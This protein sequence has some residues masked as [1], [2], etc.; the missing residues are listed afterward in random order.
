[1]SNGVNTDRDSVSVA[2]AYVPDDLKTFLT[3]LLNGKK[4][5]GDISDKFTRAAE[6]IGHDIVYSVT[7]GIRK[8]PK[9]ILLPFAVKSL[10]G[11][12]ELEEIDAILCLNK[13]SR[14]EETV[15]IP[16]CIHPHVPTTLGWEGWDNIYRLEE[17]LSGK[18]TS[19]RVNGIA[20]QEKT[21]GPF[22]PT[23]S[24]AHIEKTR[25]RSVKPTLT[26]IPEYNA[27]ERDGPL[28]RTFIL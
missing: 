22:L 8:P 7:N 25:K 3:V 21:Y 18:E 27:G 24:D 28:S 5:K 6:S 9:H 26:Y 14:F 10:T 23:A 2:K 1:L 12:A 4:H 20:V 13:L 11:N 15:P 16:E 17:T 19:H